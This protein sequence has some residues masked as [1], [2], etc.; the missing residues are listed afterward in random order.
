VATASPG[1]GGGPAEAERLGGRGEGGISTRVGESEGRK[2]Y[3]IAIIGLQTWTTLKR[4]PKRC[5]F[6]IIGFLLI[7][8]IFLI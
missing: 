4:H 5:D 6:A 1:K 2:L 8:I 7:L 3:Y